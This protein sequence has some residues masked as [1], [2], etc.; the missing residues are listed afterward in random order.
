M[1]KRN[2][3]NVSLGG[4]WLKGRAGLSVGSEVLDTQSHEPVVASSAKTEATLTMLV[5]ISV[6]SIST[7]S[8]PCSKE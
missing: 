5:D 7:W 1:V 4:L 2:S 3:E 8:G 6:C